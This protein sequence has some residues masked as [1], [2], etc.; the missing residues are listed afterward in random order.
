M[1]ILFVCL[2]NICRSPAAEGVFRQMLEERGLGVHVSVDS[3]GTS[4]H[5][6]GEPPDAR[7]TAHAARRGYRLT[8]AARGFE[9]PQDLERFDLIVAMD[10][11]NLRNITRLDADGKYQAKIKLFTDFCTIH[12][13]QGV[14]DPYYGGDDGF[15]LVMDIVEDGCAGLLAQVERFGVKPNA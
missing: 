9:A 11:S 4:A 2:G 7:M 6:E 1:K 5:H 15:E 13:R 12:E 10:Q 3:A 8:G 14:P